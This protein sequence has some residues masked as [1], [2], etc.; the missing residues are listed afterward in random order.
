V[1]E[2]ISEEVANETTKQMAELQETYPDA[3]IH[4][5]VVPRVTPCK[6]MGR[7]GL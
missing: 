5:G 4:D 3:F 2:G 6:V 7:Y 1:Q